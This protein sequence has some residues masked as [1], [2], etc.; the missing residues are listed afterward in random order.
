MSL[1]VVGVDGSEPSNEALRYALHQAT[2]EGA[3]IR[4]V[5]A[6]HVPAATYGGPGASPLVNVRELFEEDAEAIS[7]TALDS[8]RAEDGDVKIDA[9]IREGHPAKVLLDAAADA[10]LLVVGSRG[11]GGFSELLLGSVSHECA[12]HST[13]PIVIVHRRSGA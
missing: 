6:W 7:A 1:I 5:T 3:E 13:C 2:L 8:V 12:Q 4:A 9:V 10:D 11:L